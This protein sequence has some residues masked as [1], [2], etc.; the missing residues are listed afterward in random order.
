MNSNSLF[1][2]LFITTFTSFFSHAQE[3]K[4]LNYYG[5][6]NATTTLIS[7]YLFRG[8]SQSDE[9]PALQGSVD[10]SHR[11]GL[12]AG[13]WASNVDFNDGNQSRVE[14]DYYAGYIHNVED[15]AFEGGIVHYSYPG[16]APSLQYDYTELKAAAAYTYHDITTQAT[17]FFSTDYFGGAGK[18]GYYELAASKPVGDSFNVFAHA[19]H[20]TIE[21]NQNYGVPDYTNWGIGATYMHELADLTVQYSDTDLSRGE[22][23]DGCEAGI[24]FSIS[25]TF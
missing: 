8:I 9:K 20:Q 4:D 5:E 12:Y 3:P 25:K 19:G 18:S 24:L 21:V 17:V 6:L 22:C 23:N 14:I 11:N 16:A 10:W 15:W 13:I 1:T 2:T 7:E